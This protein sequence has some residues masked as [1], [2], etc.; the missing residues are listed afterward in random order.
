M[1]VHVCNPNT[2]EAEAGE[3][4]VQGQPG[5]HREFKASLSNIV[6]ADSKQTKINKTWLNF[7]DTR[8]NE[9]SQCK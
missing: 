4:Q 6:D 2:K 9:I 5:L 7:K 3:S 8:L 1:V